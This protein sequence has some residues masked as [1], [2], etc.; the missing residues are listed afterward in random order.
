MDRDPRQARGFTVLE[1]LIVVSIIAV[2]AGM[3]TALLGIAG[4]QARRA[5]SEATMRK[6]AT[7]IRMFQRDNG[8]LPYQA[9]YPVAGAGAAVVLQKGWNDYPDAVSPAEPFPNIL[10]R[11]LARTMDASEQAAVHTAAAT[12]AAKYGYY[13]RLRSASSGSIELGSTLAYCKEHIQALDGQVNINLTLTST[14]DAARLSSYLNRSAAD[15]ARRAIYAG[16]LDLEG[17]LIAGPTST[18]AAKDLTATPLLTG[19]E[20]GSL[21]TGWCDDYLE[22]GLAE[23]DRSGDAVIDAWGRPLVYV[24]MVVPR[25]RSTSAWIYNTVVKS[26]D[27][28]WYGMGA[29]GYRANTGPWAGLVADR[30]WRVLQNGRVTVG[31]NAV[32]N[33]P[34][35]V[36]TGN[37]GAAMDSDRRWF[38]APGFELDFELWSA[39]PDGR[40]AW[41]RS[42][43]ANRDNV[44]AFAYDRGLQ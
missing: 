8:V 31:A 2:L 1:L 16:A 17:P 30:R 29:T 19:A 43:P 26:Q 21:T 20:A 10:A 34:A 22:G 41:T 12:A 37:P 7:A 35:G 18:A 27:L 44:P 38:A 39:G 13:A 15:R 40:F 11:R 9:R 36:L 32:D 6:V 33:R 24:C 3:F 28:V 42:D 23:R 4:R 5:N 25:Q 14:V